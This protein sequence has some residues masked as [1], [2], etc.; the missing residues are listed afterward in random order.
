M[1]IGLQVSEEFVAERVQFSAFVGSRGRDCGMGRMHQNVPQLRL[2]HKILKKG[3][4]I[5][6]SIS[7]SH[8]VVYKMTL[9]IT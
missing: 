6:F 2:T 4:E 1:Q 5:F 7:M 8:V 9:S 3:M